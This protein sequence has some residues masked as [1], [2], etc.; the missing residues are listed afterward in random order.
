MEEDINPLSAQR[1]QQELM[2][3]LARVD[4]R[5]NSLLV[6]VRSLKESTVSKAE[7]NPVK[8]LVY[9]LVAVMM[10]SMIIALLSLVLKK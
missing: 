2:V 8:G 1:H 7:F 10:T 5:T 6:E 4:E 9:G 3:M